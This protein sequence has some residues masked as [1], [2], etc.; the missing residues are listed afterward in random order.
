M[1]EERF[2]IKKRHVYNLIRDLASLPRGLPF[3]ADLNLPFIPHAVKVY[4]LACR[5]SGGGGNFLQSLNCNFLAG[6]NT[7]TSQTAMLGI[8]PSDGKSEYSLPVGPYLMC[9]FISNNLR[10][11]AIFQQIA[12]DTTELVPAVTTRSFNSG[13]LLLR[14]EFVEFVKKPM[15]DNSF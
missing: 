13:M 12:W 8:F 11:P 15:P 14:M 3:S 6:N 9:N 1:S 5:N 10:C 7:I 4:E 2:V